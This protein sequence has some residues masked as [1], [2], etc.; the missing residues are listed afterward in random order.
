[1]KLSEIGPNNGAIAAMVL[2]NSALPEISVRS[3][4]NGKIHSMLVAAIFRPLGRWV[5]SQPFSSRKVEE[6]LFTMARRS[7]SQV[8][9]KPSTGGAQ[10]D[11][12]W[13]NIV[14]GMVPTSG[15]DGTN[16]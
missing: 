9:L 6:S 5:S 10:I 2:Q 7:H 14:L 13:N 4:L 3:D 15:R 16:F 12:Y 11:E 1:V 8:Q